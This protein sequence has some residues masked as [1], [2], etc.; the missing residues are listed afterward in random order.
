[1]F[2]WKPSGGYR[3]NGMAKVGAM[4]RLVPGGRANLPSSVTQMSR[5]CLECGT[6]DADDCGRLFSFDFPFASGDFG[7]NGFGASNAIARDTS[8]SRMR[9]QQFTGI[10]LSNLQDQVISG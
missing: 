8:S 10:I 4:M 1:M 5:F 9:H 6:S 3:T 2:E 7:W